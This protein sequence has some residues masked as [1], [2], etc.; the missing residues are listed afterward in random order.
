MK[1]SADYSLLWSMK[2]KI[3]CIDVSF[4]LDRSILTENKEGKWKYL[5]RGTHELT[6]RT[7]PKSAT[8]M[9]QDKIH[10][11]VSTSQDGAWDMIRIKMKKK[12]HGFKRYTWNKR[13]SFKGKEEWYML[14]P[15]DFLTI[16]NGSVDKKG[17][18]ELYSDDGDPLPIRVKLLQQALP[19]VYTALI[20]SGSRVRG[21]WA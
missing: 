19:K 1:V 3:T 4:D 21:L 5:Y 2:R 6:L 16:R 8:E 12:S 20:R 7:M 18:E 13:S 14:P 9:S 17:I 10:F 11:Y 15:L